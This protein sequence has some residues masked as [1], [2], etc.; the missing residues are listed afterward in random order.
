MIS[1][2][3]TRIL[4]PFVGT[5]ISVI[6]IARHWNDGTRP[7]VPFVVVFSGLMVWWI[8]T[9]TLGKSFSIIP[10]AKDLVQRG[11]YSKIRHPIYFGFSLTV[12][13]WAMIA[14][15]FLTTLLVLGAICSSFVRMYF[16]EKKLV[17]AFGEHYRSYRRRTWF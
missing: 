5:Y 3:K 8:A 11:I 7:T 9:V 13:G 15:S 14:P 1:Q 10:E 4:Y 16:E 17:K 12:I 2:Y 6:L